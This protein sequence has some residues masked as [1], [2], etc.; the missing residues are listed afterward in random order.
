MAASLS[1]RRL[2]RPKLLGPRASMQ[3]CVHVHGTCIMASGYML[4]MH[5]VNGH[6]SCVHVHIHMCA[7]VAWILVSK[8]IFIECMGGNYRH[9][10]SVWSTIKHDWCLPQCK[11]APPRT[12][13]NLS[14]TKR[15]P[16]STTWIFGTTKTRKWTLPSYV[17]G[18]RAC[19]S[20]CEGGGPTTCALLS[21][22]HHK[23]FAITVT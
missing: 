19:L 3:T 18:L 17:Q 8:G 16:T 20:I 11:N 12:R 1:A 21:V 13:Q 7:H 15:P 14:I 10:R 4:A 6:V 22:N 2:Q 9:I 5:C 23:V